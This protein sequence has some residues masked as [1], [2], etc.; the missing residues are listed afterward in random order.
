MSDLGTASGLADQLDD[1]LAALDQPFD[2]AKRGALLAYVQLLAKWN[3]T[4]NLTA[5]R[6]P[7]RMITHHLLDS[8]AVL[9]VLGRYARA[10]TTVL[11]VGSGAGLPG[12]PIA[13]SRPDWSVTM[14]EPV[15]KKSAFI[16]QAIGE[17]GLRNATS[18]AERVE[19]FRPVAR[20]SIVI[21]RAFS[22]LAT[23]AES[24]A[25]TLDDDGVLVAMKGVHP[26]EE[27]RELSDAF[28]IDAIV[29]ITV[30]SI[31]AARHVIV[32]KPKR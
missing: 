12:I 19:H 20:F 18:H 23:F 26:H 22:D 25:H 24:S 31:D 10:S 21:S 11:D 29:P 9:P 27:L 30:P 13:L 14:L 5:I 2:V 3:G 15:H 16:T 6:E 1:G 8:L 17:L 28:A 7:S 32:V 4:Y